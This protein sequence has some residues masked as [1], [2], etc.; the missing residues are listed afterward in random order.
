MLSGSLLPYGKGDFSSK[1]LVAVFRKP[2]L[3]LNFYWLDIWTEWVVQ[4]LLQFDT[5]LL[6]SETLLQNL[7]KF[8]F[9]YVDQF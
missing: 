9:F 1:Y 7:K 4:I 8:F 2:C 5:A 6:K 3:P